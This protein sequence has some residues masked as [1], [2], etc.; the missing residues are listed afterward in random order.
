[1]KAKQ[2]LGLRNKLKLTQQ[3]LADLIGAQRPTIA[4]W[5]IGMNE[6]KGANL[7]A[8]NELSRKSKAKP[9]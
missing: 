6:P 5:E 9:K 2:I 3:Q 7:K 8:L 4:R 1:M